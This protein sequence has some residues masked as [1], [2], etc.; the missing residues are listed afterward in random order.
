MDKEEIKWYL[1]IREEKLYNV[2]DL[3]RSRKIMIDFIT[4]MIGGER[5][6]KVFSELKSIGYHPKL[7]SSRTTLL[8]FMFWELVEKLMEDYL[9]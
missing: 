5:T 2:K 4:E 6:G 8:S 7:Q 3:D 9:K 1:K